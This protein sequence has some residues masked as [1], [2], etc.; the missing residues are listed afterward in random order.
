[1]RWHKKEIRDS[2]DADIMSHH[3]D[4]EPWHTLDHFDPESA[5]D[6]RSVRFGLSMDGL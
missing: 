6:P 4:A 3:V 2:K 5:K 1:M